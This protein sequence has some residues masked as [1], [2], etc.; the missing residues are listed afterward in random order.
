MFI[1]MPAY[2][3]CSSVTVPFVNTVV[4][5]DDDDERMNFNAA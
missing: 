3:C 1:F 2:I 5:D 4:D